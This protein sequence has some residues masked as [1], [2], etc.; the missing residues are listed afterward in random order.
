MILHP[1]FH[2]FARPYHPVVS[3]LMM[4]QYDATFAA[5]MMFPPQ[6][7]DQLLGQVVAAAGKRQLRVA[8]TEKYPHVTYFFQWRQLRRLTRARIAP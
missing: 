5:P 7:M 4:T 3:Y 2:G 6:S 1:D 8:E